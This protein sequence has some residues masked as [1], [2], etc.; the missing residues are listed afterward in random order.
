MLQW[1][2]DRIG[3]WTNARWDQHLRHE[4]GDEATDALIEYLGFVKTAHAPALAPTRSATC[5]GCAIET[6]IGT[7]GNPH[8]VPEPF[9]TCRGPIT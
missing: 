7:E 5:V 8:P 6:E 9:H 4:F 1:L 3:S 2:L